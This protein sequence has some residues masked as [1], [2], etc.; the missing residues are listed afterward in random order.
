ASHP[1]PSL[2]DALPI[3]FY[4]RGSYNF[5][6]KYTV[7]LLVRSDGSSNAQP[8]NRWLVTPTLSLGWNVKNDLLTD[9]AMFS[10][11]NV[12]ASAGRLRSEEH[13]SELQSREN[14]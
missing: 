6:D 5:D 1:H 8:T 13:T 4:G 14:L 7:S 3:S 12:R 9:D 10:T 2:H 11:F